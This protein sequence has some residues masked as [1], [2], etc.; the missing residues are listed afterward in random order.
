MKHNI[1]ITVLL[2]INLAIIEQEVISVY[3]NCDSNS[4]GSIDFTIGEVVT[5]TLAKPIID[6][7]Y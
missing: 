6:L 1:I 7:K 5:V 4:N 3:G 2:I